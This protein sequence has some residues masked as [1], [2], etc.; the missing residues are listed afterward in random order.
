MYKKT[1]ENQT[2]A[3]NCVFKCYVLNTQFGTTL[4]EL[5]YYLHDTLQ[6]TQQIM[7]FLICSDGYSAW[8]G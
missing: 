8:M 6:E 1:S 4:R 3:A 7:N 2:C 5:N